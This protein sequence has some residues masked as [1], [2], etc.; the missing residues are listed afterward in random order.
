MPRWPTRPSVG[1]LGALLCLAACAPTTTVS[2]VPTAT[3]LPT[4]AAT[5][6][7]VLAPTPI[8]VPSGWQ[9]LA[10]THF[11]MAYP[12][13]WTVE[14]APDA[15]V[16]SYIIW[17]P[18]KQF[19]VQV[20]V[21]PPAEVPQAELTLYCLPESAGARHTTL[22]NLPMTVQLTGLDNTVGVWRFVNAQQT[23]YLLE[24]G[25]VGASPAVQAQDTAIFATFR[26]DN[27]TPWHC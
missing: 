26:P 11:S 10:T 21:V 17:A 1:F 7:S 15:P 8:S 13:T 12:P 6:T 5:P 25:G 3:T 22:A 24:A 27:A 9:V 18:A 2:L 16:P 19:A 14:G 20:M 23:L 4:P